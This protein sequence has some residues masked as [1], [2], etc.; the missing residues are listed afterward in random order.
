MMPY[1][2]SPPP[3]RR[4]QLTERNPSTH[5]LSRASSSAGKGSTTKLH[6]LHA[7]GHGRHFHA[8]IPSHGKNLNK[9][10]KLTAAHGEEEHVRSKDQPKNK[11]QT[12]PSSPSA[13]NTKHD[14]SNV[15]LARSGSKVSIKKNTSYLSHKRNKSSSK[16]GNLAKAD[17]AQRMSSDKTNVNGVQ[18]SMGS[19]E[20]DDAWTEADS[21][22][23]P[24]VIRRGS[25][26]RG[27]AQSR[28]PLSPD[29]P[30]LRSPTQL[31]DSPPQSPL[32]TGHEKHHSSL[33]PQ[34]RN[35]TYSH[36]PDAELVTNRLL[37][38]NT[39][40]NVQPQTSIISAT[41]TPS[42]SSGSPAFNFSQ[43]ATLRDDQSM[44][45]DGVSRF[46]NATGSSSANETPASLSHHLSSAPVG[47]HKNNEQNQTT[48]FPST[49]PTQAADRSNRSHHTVSPASFPKQDQPTQSRSSSPPL[50][51]Q[52]KPTLR[53]PQPSPFASAARDQQ[54]Q[55]LTQQK[56]DL[57]RES[58]IREPA[59]APA[60]QPP[61]SSAQ[62]SLANLSLTNS[63]EGSI[64][65]RKRKQWEQAETEYGNVR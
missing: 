18:F 15:N 53:G 16:L 6:K 34:E 52:Q 42:G 19:D 12:P 62:A 35:G 9:L 43:D 47:V 59:H 51:N 54:H 1:H 24:D 2:E 45:S 21:S 13:A 23:S 17:K 22:Q 30:P 36:P 61:L 55:S 25:I 40:S 11:V 5:S 8:K 48:S 10:S 57:Q 37:S 46:L 28:E 20:Q 32:A 50:P 63:N 41:I 33:H 38:R 4:P 39:A 27:Q 14:P 31:P 49:S 65:D 44:P 60:I 7:V 26:S 29:G 58:T 64:E 3:A 56:L